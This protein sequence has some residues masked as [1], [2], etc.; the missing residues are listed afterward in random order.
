MTI[1]FRPLKRVAL[2]AFQRTGGFNLVADSDWRR[3]RL[4]ILCY[5]GISLDDEHLWNG[6]LNM[7]P[8]LLEQRLLLL[9]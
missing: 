8:D 4:L 5:H 2:Q 3:Q 7:P 6:A 9:Q 1:S